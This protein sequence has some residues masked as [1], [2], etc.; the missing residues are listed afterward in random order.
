MNNCGHTHACY[1]ADTVTRTHA[2]TRPTH[3]I[4]HSRHTQTASRRPFSSLST[5]GGGLQDS[6]LGMDASWT[7]P[8]QTAL[9]HYDIIGSVGGMCVVKPKRIPGPGTPISVPSTHASERR[10]VERHKGQSWLARAC[11]AAFGAAFVAA[12]I[13]ACAQLVLRPLLRPFVAALPT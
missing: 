5:V 2:S 4:T 13:A 1:C 9:H 10:R 3:C 11:D 12:L 8:P 7:K 6:D